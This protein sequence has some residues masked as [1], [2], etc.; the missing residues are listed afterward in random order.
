MN[1]KQTHP[2]PWI[3]TII[4]V[5]LLIFLGY[6]PIMKSPKASERTRALYKGKNLYV[7][8]FSFA[9][10]H[11][12]IYP[13]EI[14]ALENES[15]NTAEAC[16]TQLLNREE[17]ESEEIFW[18]EKNTALGKL[19]KSNIPIL[20]DSG[21]APGTFSTNVWNGKAIVVKLSGSTTAM[22]INFKG[23]PLTPEGHPKSGFILEQRGPK[24]VNI[25]APE[26]LPEGATILLPPLDSS[27]TSYISKFHRFS[28]CI[29]Q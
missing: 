10:E 4:T 21:I 12:G 22:D 20:F 3:V 6:G 19:N 27:K 18:V 16:F 26:N 5:A 24:H 15:G 14:T 23:A 28:P 7:A 9:K 1:D 2:T 13:S 25:F 11:D 29:M 17:I 8:L